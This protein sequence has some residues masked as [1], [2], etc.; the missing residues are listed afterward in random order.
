M[1]TDTRAKHSSSSDLTAK[2]VRCEYG[3]AHARIILS[4]K[5]SV[6]SNAPDIIT[7]NISCCSVKET[8]T[9]R[10]FHGMQSCFCRVRCISSLTK[11]AYLYPRSRL[12]VVSWEV[13]ISFVTYSYELHV[14]GNNAL[15]NSL[16]LNSNKH[17]ELGS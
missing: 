17:T 11:Q 3:Y 2:A 5:K 13:S 10:Y 6:R 8:I 4:N 14:S 15:C 9:V 16:K 7:N 12:S 1:L